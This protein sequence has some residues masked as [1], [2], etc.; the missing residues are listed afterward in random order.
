[1]VHAAQRQHLRTI[2]ARRHVADRL[3]LR[4]DQRALRPQEAVGV[5]LHLHAAVAED[6]RRH[7]PQHVYAGDLGPP[8]DWCGLVVG[9]GGAGAD[10]GDEV[11]LTDHG[12]VPLGR[13]ERHHG[14]PVIERALQDDVRVDADQL[15]GAVGITVARAGLAG[16]DEAHHR[17]GVAADAVVPWQSLGHANLQGPAPG[18]RYCMCT[19]ECAC[20]IRP[21][22]LGATSP[23]RTGGSRLMPKATHASKVPAAC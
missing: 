13:A 10:G 9:I 15:S 18:C 22:K 14:T 23:V 7:T 3:A 19:N 8:D 20:Y 2:L 6:P 12:A 17:A 21:V 4:P 5:D 11:L 1:M 16:A